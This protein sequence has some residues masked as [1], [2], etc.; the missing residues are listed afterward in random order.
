MT[1]VACQAASNHAN[2]IKKNN[3]NFLYVIKCEAKN[4]LSR[5]QGYI[6]VCFQLWL[7]EEILV[8]IGRQIIIT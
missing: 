7:L 5:P 1:V 4:I 8:L 3:N 6:I 2:R